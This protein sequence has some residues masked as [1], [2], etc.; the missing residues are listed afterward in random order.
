MEECKSTS[1]PVFKPYNQNQ[2]M[3]LPPSLE[4]LIPK[5]HLVRV[6][7]ET[8]D[9]MQLEPLIE[10]YKGGGTSSYHPKM[11][12]KVLVYGYICK[13]YSS[14]QLAKALRENVNFMWLAAGNR[15][16]FRTINH[17]R[18]SRLKQTVEEVFASLLEHLIEIGYVKLEHYF[19]DGTKLRADARKYTHVWAKNTER[20]KAS[21]QKKIKALLKEIEA[22]NEAEQ[23]E[24]G[25]R[26]LEELGEEVEVSSERLE[27]IVQEIDAKLSGAQAQDKQLERVKRKI[28]REFLPRQKK[29]EEQERLLGGRNSYSKTDPD[30]TFFRYKNGELLPSYNVL[31][32]TE[33]QFI[34]NWSIHQNP[35]DGVAFISHMEKFKDLMQ[36]TPKH[37]MGDSAF[38]V[39]ENYAYLGERQIGNYLKYPTFH[40][41][42]SGKYKEKHPYHRDNF[43]YDESEDSYQCP[44]GRRLRFKESGERRSAQGYV[45]H[46]DLYECEDCS[47]CEAASLCKKGAGPRTLQRNVQLEAYRREAW[48]NLTSPEGVKLRKQRN[49]DVEPVIG[50]IKYTMGYR[51]FRLRGREKVNIEMGLLS[52]AHNI[53]KMFTLA[54]ENTTGA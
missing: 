14:R 32:G 24:Y 2:L 17:F 11:L 12:L 1:P 9:K 31:I 23:R 28:S 4:E 39:E 8:I 30:A 45:S 33:N 27:E 34:L 36:R 50:H 47:S 49:I 51:R 54:T 25:D 13:I 21:L 19:V 3:L 52:I 40:Q 26:D 15:P 7:N 48:E 10:S 53:I 22:V 42:L 38:G 29:Y 44:Q 20:Y 46:F 41:E 18:S 37:C 35:N 6:V 16:D 43:L 5:D